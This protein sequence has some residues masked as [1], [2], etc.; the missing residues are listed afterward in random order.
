MLLGT[1]KR[2][3]LYKFQIKINQIGKPRGINIVK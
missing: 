3:I 2:V 1:I